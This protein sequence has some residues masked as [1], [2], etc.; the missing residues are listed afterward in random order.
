VQIRTEKMHRTAEF[1]YAS[2]AYYKQP[3]HSFGGSGSSGKLAGSSLSNMHTA[4]SSSNSAAANGS[5]VGRT[6]KARYRIPWLTCITEWQ[7]EIKSSREF[8]GTCSG[9]YNELMLKFHLAVA[10]RSC[11]RCTSHK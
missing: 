1:G 2:H 6:G 11:F 5:S 7:H 8:V 4:V 3:D 10:M 9:S